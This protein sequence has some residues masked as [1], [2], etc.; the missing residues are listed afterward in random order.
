MRRV[1]SESG[2][3]GVGTVIFLGLAGLFV[4]LLLAAFD[5]DSAFYGR[6]PVPGIGQ[7]ELPEGETDVYYSEA[8]E[9]GAALS[10]VS[11]LEFSVIGPDQSSARVDARG[12]DAEETDGGMTRVI[13]AVFAPAEATY[14]V[15]V[16]S[17][18]ARQRSG[19]ELTFGQSP[20]GAVGDRFD[21]VVDELNGPVGIVIAGVLV[22]L[23][24][25]PRVR[26]AADSRR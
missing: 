20:I 11:D 26:R 18:E 25:L 13:A 6:V 3:V 2:A 8:I 16:E 12:G 7:V 10:P 19:P 24:L 15:T 14:E 21:S 17:A 1:S 23:V 4:Y 5:A 22:I 9:A